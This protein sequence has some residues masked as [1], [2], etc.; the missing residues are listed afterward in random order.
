MP[1]PIDAAYRCEFS[2]DTPIDIKKR[3]HTGTCICG[4]KGSCS[5]D[6]F[7]KGRFCR[8]EK[9]EYYQAGKRLDKNEMIMIVEE[10]GCQ[11]LSLAGG[12]SRAQLTFICRCGFQ[13]ISSWYHFYRDKWCR[14][15]QCEYYHRPKKLTTELTKAW[16]EYE[17][18]KVPDNFEYKSKYRA[19]DTHYDL[20]CPEGHTFDASIYMW[21]MGARCKVCNGDGRTLSFREI[22]NFYEDQNCELLYD[23]KDFTGDV[24]KSI[25]PYICSEGH[26]I[27]NMTKNNFN[28]RLNLGIGPCAI[29][30]EAAR[31]RKKEHAKYVESC[32]KKYG[33]ENV[34]QVAKIFA[35]Q[36]DSL[37][38]T[39]NY[40][41]PSGKQIL[42]Q[43]YE[44]RCMKL[45]LED[46]EEEEIL[47]DPEDMPEIWYFNPNKQREA[48]Y[49]PDMYIPDQDLV[50]EVKSTWTLK[51]ELERNLSKFE[52]AVKA[53]F[54]LH[55]YVFDEKCLLYRKIY[56]KEGVVV[57][58]HP[59]AELVFEELEVAC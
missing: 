43:G 52:G 49:Y 7:V 29:C 50:I 16:I 14:H 45:L 12:G 20:L 13:Q 17:N 18:Y 55:L 38:R 34:M 3:R 5:Y 6:S 44:P 31:D 19:S 24:S 33:V 54:K 25:I 32:K 51:M 48:R 36:R 42:L 37:K 53:G 40:T 4:T 41:C 26:T 11:F 39:K 59:P 2:L 58:P 57:C 15:Y 1:N 10:K 56:T 46:Y 30:R 35:K 47:T 9:C 23:E 28:T 8:N 21:K 22:K 27:D